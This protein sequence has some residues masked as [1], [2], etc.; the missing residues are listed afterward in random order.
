MGFLLG[1]VFAM[2]SVV[3]AGLADGGGRGGVFALVFGVG[4]IVILPIFYGVMGFIQGIIVSVIYNF[5][6]GIVGGVELNLQGP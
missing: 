5:L 6:A 2:L 4:G 3:G 1:L